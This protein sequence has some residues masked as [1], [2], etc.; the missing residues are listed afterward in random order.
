M[1][2]SWLI[3]LVSRVREFVATVVAIV[4]LLTDLKRLLREAF[5]QG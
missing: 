3:G 4:A 1:S 5:A 2:M